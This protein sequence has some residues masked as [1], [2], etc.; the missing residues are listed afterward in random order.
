[1]NRTKA[2]TDLRNLASIAATMDSYRDPPAS[3]R[4]A[5]ALE[6]VADAMEASSAARQRAVIRKAE[7]IAGSLASARK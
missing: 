1:M 6:L 5:A 3:V 7:R 2:A 4:L